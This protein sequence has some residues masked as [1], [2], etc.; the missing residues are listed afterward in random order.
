MHYLKGNARCHRTCH[1]IT[2]WSCRKRISRGTSS[3]LALTIQRFC[4]PR[5][6]SLVPAPFAVEQR[7]SLIQTVSTRE[8]LFSINVLRSTAIA[9]PSILCSIRLQ[10]VHR[11][12][13]GGD[14][15]RWLFPQ[16]NTPSTTFTSWWATP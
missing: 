8:D 14:V 1:S 11:Q 9:V 3:L 15:F 5:K 6:V 4:S 7:L 10:V 13:I 16:T 12:A 2:T